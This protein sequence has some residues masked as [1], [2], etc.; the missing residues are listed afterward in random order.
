M[1]HFLQKVFLF[2][3]FL[4]ATGIICKAQPVAGFTINYPDPVCNPA[5]ISFTNT[6]TG[7]SPLTYQW[8]LVVDSVADTT[9]NPS[10]LFSS[11]GS[12]SVELIATDSFLLSDTIS[13]TVTINCAP[14]AA[15]TFSASS[16]CDSATVQFNDT[17]V[18]QDSIVTW[19]W[20]FG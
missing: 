6:S 16:V 18:S 9:A 17:S 2:L 13:E 11:C 14:Q 10:F 3:S 15:F 8:Y 19:K 1:K 5:T 20:T 4:I 12:F 7:S